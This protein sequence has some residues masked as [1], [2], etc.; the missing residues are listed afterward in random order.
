[1]NTELLEL[2]QDMKRMVEEAT[3]KPAILSVD[4]PTT[5]IDDGGR[6]ERLAALWFLRVSSRI[7]P[8]N[9]GFYLDVYG[10]DHVRVE[11]WG[12]KYRAT[13]H[14]YGKGCQDT[15]N[16]GRILYALLPASLR[17]PT[18]TDIMS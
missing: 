8:D 11:T 1:M 7:D 17:P 13:M 14:L 16:L 3:G 12:K 2:F 4:K 15:V 6:Y 5:Q 18:E 10:P 9:H